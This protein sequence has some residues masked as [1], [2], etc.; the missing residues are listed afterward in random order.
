LIWIKNIRSS[1]DD[2]V[3]FEDQKESGHSI[4]CMRESVAGLNNVKPNNKKLIKVLD[5][6][7]RDTQIIPNQILIY[8]FD[9]GSIEKFIHIY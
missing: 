4:R 3:T 5:L 1:S 7:G 8:V 6:M 2:I 9:D